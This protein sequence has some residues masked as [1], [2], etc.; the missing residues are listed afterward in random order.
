MFYD[1]TTIFTVAHLHEGTFY[2]NNKNTIDELS[3]VNLKRAYRI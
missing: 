3:V 1:I 2:Y